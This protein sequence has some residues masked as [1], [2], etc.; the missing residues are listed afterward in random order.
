MDS[1]PEL[2]PKTFLKSEPEPQQN[3]TF[4]QHYCQIIEAGGREGVGTHLSM[5]KTDENN[6][7]VALYPLIGGEIGNSHEPCFWIHI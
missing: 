3:V 6:G 4:P 1:E 7:H 5:K 2:E